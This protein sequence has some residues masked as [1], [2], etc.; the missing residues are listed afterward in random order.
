[1]LIEANWGN[2]RAKFDGR[3]EKAFEFFCSLLFYKE[4]NQPT[5]ALSYLNQTGLETDPVT[6]G[7]DVI[8]WQAKFLGTSSAIGKNKKKLTK[9]IEDAKRLH[10]ALTRI[11]F[12]FNVDFPTNTR[13]Q[14]KEPLYKTE[15]EA[16]AK[17]HGIDIVWKTASFF[18]TPFVCE[19]N[20]VVA[21]H[22]FEL[23]PSV[24]TFLQELSRHT[25]TVLAPIRSEIALKGV[26]IKIER[27]SLVKRLHAMLSSSPLVIVSGEAGVGKTAVVKDLY[28]QINGSSPFFVFK[29]TEF[30]VAHINQLFKEYGPFTLEDLVRESEAT[31]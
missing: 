26:T 9:A 8:G 18:K 19:T 12:Y 1:M 3:E 7:N 20:A 22:F 28:A 17:S 24:V 10:P 16:H 31:F 30:N 2:F 23:G 14:G 11:H 6:I 13:A 15:I 25:E 27:T 29:A 5:G 4:H 21:K